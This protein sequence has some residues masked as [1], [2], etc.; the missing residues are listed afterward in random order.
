MDD[1]QVILRRFFDHSCDLLCVLDQENRFLEVSPSWQNVVGHR[2]ADLKSVDAFKYLHLDDRAAVIAEAKKI[3]SHRGTDQ[4]IDA[5]F[6]CLG[7]DFRWLRWSWVSDGSLIFASVRDIFA[8]KKEPF[9]LITMQ[10]KSFLETVVAH[11]PSM[12]FVKEASDLRFRLLNKS[13]ENI[14][15]RKEQDLLGKN[16]YDFFPQE[17]A[18]FFTSMDRKVIDAG[19]IVDIPEEMIKTASGEK[20][21]HTRKVPVY[22][23]DGTP[24]LLIGISEDITE[25]RKEQRRL[26]LLAFASEL[27]IWEWNLITNEVDYDERWCA[28]VGYESH[29][30]EKS[31]GAWGRLVHPDDKEPTLDKVQHYLQGNAS[32]FET[33]FRMRHRDGHWVPILSRGKIFRRAADGS[34]LV[35]L[36]TNCDLTNLQRT[37]DELNVQRQLALHSAKLASIGELAAGIGHEIN[38]PLA[39]IIGNLEFLLNHSLENYP[40]DANLQSYLQKSSLA[41]DRIRRIVS[42]LRTFSYGLQPEIKKVDLTEAIDSTLMLIVEIFRTKGISVVF[43]EPKFKAFIMGDLGQLQQIVMNLLSNARDAVESCEKKAIEITISAEGSEIVLTVKDS[44]VGIKKEDLANVFT[45]FFTTKAVTK[46]NGLG[47]AISRK[48]VES[49]KGS[50]GF[51]SEE[52]KGS[53]FFVRFPAIELQNSTVALDESRVARKELCALIVDDEQEIGEIIGLILEDLGFKVFLAKNA[54][55]GLALY[56]ENSFDMILTDL[57]MPQMNGSDFLLR[58]IAMTPKEKL[59]KLFVL[60]GGVDTKESLSAKKPGLLLDEVLYK[61]VT[62]KQFQE[63]LNRNF[64]PRD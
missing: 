35:L 15:G 30:I 41:T 12:I 10:Q 45:A 53:S 55:E 25:R 29:E 21:L 56:R 5:R 31:L 19:K 34:A 3:R 44:G 23:K 4:Y 54:E 1:G 7:G 43:H 37:E 39:I 59:P 64:G 22:G 57:N 42:G 51:S 24:E 14:L 28:I 52:G 61:P 38:N 11:V 20:W 18:D 16:D 60:T 6:Q 58:I 49:M 50:I 2:P 33:K 47:L 62:R 32:S 63:V 26:E 13:G 17:Q 48:L 8:Q 27:G 46:G 40:H 9:D 36:G